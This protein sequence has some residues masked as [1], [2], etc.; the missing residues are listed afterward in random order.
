MAPPLAAGYAWLAASRGP[1]LLSL[2][3]VV[4]C[5]CGAKSLRLYFRDSQPLPSTPPYPLVAPSCFG[6]GSA[7]KA[8]SRD[9]HHR[10]VA[11]RQ[12]FALSAPLPRCCCCCCCRC[13]CR[14]RSRSL[15]SHPKQVVDGRELDVPRLQANPNQVGGV[16]VRFD[17]Q[18]ARLDP[19]LPT[20]PAVSPAPPPRLPHL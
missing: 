15:G 5:V 20:P 2:L 16:R 14:C 17:V 6:S 18:N 13:R 3:S 10:T 19:P 1:A 8:R 12:R 4:C 7:Q 9:V 11:Q